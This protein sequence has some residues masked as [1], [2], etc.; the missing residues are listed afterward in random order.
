MMPSFARDSVKIIRGKVKEERGTTVTDFADAETHEIIRCSFQPVSS[1]TTWTDTRQ[2]VTV[3]A[4]LYLPPSA[5]IQTG[6]IVEF[7]GVKYAIDGA[8][9]KW[10]SPS[11]CVDNIQCSLIDWQG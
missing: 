8:P 10:R 7:E 4:V 11:G 1:A 3:R 5:D 6:D 9:H 2:A